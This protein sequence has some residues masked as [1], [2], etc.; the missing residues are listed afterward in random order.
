RVGA[1][2]LRDR[3]D[4]VLGLVELGEQLREHLEVHT[5]ERGPEQ[6]RGAALVL[7]GNGEVGLGEAVADAAV[8]VVAAGRGAA[9]GEAGTGGADA[10]RGQEATAGELKAAA[11][12]GVLLGWGRAVVDGDGHFRAPAARPPMMRFW[13]RK[14]MI[15]LGRET[16][17][18]PDMLARQL[19]QASWPRRNS[20]PIG[21]VR[22]SAVEV[23]IS[24]PTYSFRLPTITM[25]VAVR[26]TALASGTTIVS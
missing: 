21:R 16:N 23:T 9:G 11:R 18:A 25:I 10:H 13:A 15:S 24:G 6:D 1:D 26:N 3:H 19:E 4:L 8:A 22:I 14:K 2:R 5:G 17:T 7:R 12:H 20:T